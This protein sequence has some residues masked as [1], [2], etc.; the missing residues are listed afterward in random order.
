MPRE[1][2]KPVIGWPY[3]VSSLGRVRR[4]TRGNATRV[5][6]ILK[7]GVSNHGYSRVVLS[8]KNVLRYVSVHTLVAEAFRGPRPAG[9]DC[10]H[11]DGVKSNCRASNL[12]WGTKK[13]NA[14]D[15]I[16]HGHQVRGETS[17][18]AK[19]TDEIVMSIRFDDFRSH[20]EIAKDYGI[21]A[22]H[23]SNLVSG[24]AWG[25]LPVNKKRPPSLIGRPPKRTIQRGSNHEADER[26]R[27]AGRVHV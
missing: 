13:E 5:G 17:A 9:K 1:T 15:A 25:H 20:P 24:R 11:K 2:W 7:P 8:H 16:K 22:G 12:K 3:E 21:T 18:H 4:A 14:A 27:A 6:K 26:I 19:I 10:L 23:V